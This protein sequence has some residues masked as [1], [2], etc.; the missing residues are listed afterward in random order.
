MNLS[1]YSLARGKFFSS[2]ESLGGLALVGPDLNENM[3]LKLKDIKSFLSYCS[4]VLSR[5]PLIKESV[6]LMTPSS[7]IAHEDLDYEAFLKTT[8]LSDNISFYFQATTFVN[9][10]PLSFSDRG[11]LGEKNEYKPFD[12]QDSKPI[13][14]MV[15]ATIEEIRAFGDDNFKFKHYRGTAAFDRA[16]THTK[17]H[18]IY[19]TDK[20]LY[21]TIIASRHNTK[22]GVTS[23]I[24]IMYIGD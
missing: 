10:A 12:S 18:T 22:T 7:K 21:M 13:D 6:E 24:A 23:Y 20:Q 16:T 2:M 4:A 17:G 8:R 9:K 19:L 3:T 14:S 1:N 11:L 15:T 5:E